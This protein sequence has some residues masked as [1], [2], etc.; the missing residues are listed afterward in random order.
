MEQYYCISLTQKVL[1]G[2]S[3][4][5][6]VLKLSMLRTVF[7]SRGTVVPPDVTQTTRREAAVCRATKAVSAALIL[8]NSLGTNEALLAKNCSAEACMPS[9]TAHKESCFFGKL[10]EKKQTH[11][12][13]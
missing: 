4:T 9:L 11:E 12:M 8:P 2:S 1:R 6:P 10:K 7:T 13:F 5:I 3:T